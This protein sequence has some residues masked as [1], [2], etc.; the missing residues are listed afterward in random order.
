[1]LMPSWGGVGK[2]ATVCRFV[3]DYGWRLLGDDLIIIG[4]GRADS[5]LKPFVIYPYHKELFPEAFEAKD[6]HT[7]KNLSVSNLMSKMI[8]TVKRLLRPFP[9]MLAYLRKHNP[10]SMRVPPQ[11]LFEAEQLSGG[12]IPYKTVWLERITEDTLNFRT[13]EVSEVVSRAVTVT[14]NELFAEKLNAV[15]HLCGCGVFDYSETFGRMYGILNETF[16]N[17][18]CYIL[19]I[20]TSVKITEVGQIIYDKL[21]DNGEE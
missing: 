20:P 13:A 2:T 1:L 18:E 4:E 19:E 9:R 8:P 11:K 17:T 21:K 3:R 10:Q 16:G 5:F 14:S 15:F 6:N 12:G 7:V